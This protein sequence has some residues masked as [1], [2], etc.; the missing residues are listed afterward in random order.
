MKAAV[1]H[2]IG[3]PLVIEE[4]DVPVPG[5]GEVLIRVAA[6]G[7][8]HSDLHQQDGSV[9]P[10][11]IPI[12]LGHENAGIVESL[13]PG[14]VGT[15]VGERVVVYGGWGCG[16][17]R[18]CLGGQEQLCSTGSW[19]GL[20]P[21]GGY[22]EYMLVPSA[23]HLIPVG[24]LDLV[25]AAALADAG[26]TPYR[27]VKKA[28]HLLQPGTTALV[29]GAGGLG[30]FGIQYLKLLTEA[31]V[32][33]VETSPERR[34]IAR[35]LGADTVIDGAG[36]DLPEAV[37][38]AASEF[39]V[40]AVFDFVGIDTT[41]QLGLGALERQGL[42]VLVGLAGGSLPVSFFGM[43]SEA[44]VTTSNWGSRNDLAEVIALARTGALTTSCE[45]Y[46]LTKINEVFDLLKEGRINGRAV[47]IP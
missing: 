44:V 2:T 21:D 9:P 3:E 33:V 47:L 17:C 25:Q 31:H 35:S 19:S 41:M 42:L 28:L 29:L 38:A 16:R 36:P 15:K 46:P 10:I 13:G 11:R 45:S 23:R 5:P 32:I 8:C 12:V 18:F 6:A 14:V 43:A 34:E 7:V 40:T 37:R 26:V 4:R 22:A 39:G 27:A 1:L 24:D 30:Q 20:G